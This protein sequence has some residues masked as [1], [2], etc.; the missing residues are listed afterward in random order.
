MIWNHP[1]E[2]T[3][4]KTGCLEFQVYILDQPPGWIYDDS[5][6]GNPL[7]NPGLGSRLDDT[8]GTCLQWWTGS[9]RRALR[10]QVRHFMPWFGWWLHFPGW[11]VGLYKGWRFLP[12]IYREYSKSSLGGGNS[13]IFYVHP[14]DWGRW[15]QIDEHYFFNG[16]VQPPTRC[17]FPSDQ[18]NS[19][20][21]FCFFL[22]GWL[23]F[24]WTVKKSFGVYLGGGFKYVFMFT[25]TCGWWSNLINMFK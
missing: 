9:Y 18:C 7:E 6:H 4:K 21:G 14:E 13:K 5:S 11:L 23:W 10:G 2:T 22:G 3:I 12:K 1:L 19:W 17:V 16:L 8:L 15:S 20:D 25:A 24:V